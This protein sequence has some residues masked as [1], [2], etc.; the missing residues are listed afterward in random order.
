MLIYS[1]NFKGIYLQ[2]STGN[3]FKYS[4]WGLNVIAVLVPVIAML[5]IFLFKNRKLQV[6][7]SF[8]N[9]VLI[10]GYYVLLFIYLWF[11][12][13]NLNATWNLHLI[14]VIPLVNIVL[15]FLAI[16]AIAKDEALVKSLNRIR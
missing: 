1:V 3:I 12:A 13:Q 8:F 11:A 5:T 2:N 4:V 6:R 7:L 10:G 14:T 16:R 9:M 15:N